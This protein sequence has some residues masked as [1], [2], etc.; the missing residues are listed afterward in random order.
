MASS[1]L[2]FHLKPCWMTQTGD[3]QK[4]YRHPLSLLLVKPAV[5][6]NFLFDLAQTCQLPDGAARSVT[7]DILSQHLP[8]PEDA[9]DTRVSS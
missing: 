2:F 5:S 9:N 1:V 8:L 6:G 4:K 7:G 3:I